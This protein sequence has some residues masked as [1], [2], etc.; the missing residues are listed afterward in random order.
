MA[1]ESVLHCVYNEHI[2]EEVEKDGYREEWR[3]AEDR[4]AREKRDQ[5]EGVQIISL[6][7][8]RECNGGGEIGEESLKDVLP[9]RPGK[10]F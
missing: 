1:I 5:V 6:E 4:V 9:S 7:Y 10:T 8:V 2:F 3:E